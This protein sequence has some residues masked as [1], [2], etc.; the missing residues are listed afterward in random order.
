MLLNIYFLREVFVYQ[1]D[2]TEIAFSANN[3]CHCDISLTSIKDVFKTL[4]NIYH[5]V[6]SEIVTAKDIIVPSEIF[7][8]DRNAPFNESNRKLLKI[9]RMQI[10]HRQK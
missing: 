10:L 5:G 7:D 8:R 9:C 3:C 4:S 1:H 6:F 2:D